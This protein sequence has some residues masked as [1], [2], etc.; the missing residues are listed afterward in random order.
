M[1][2]PLRNLSEN[3]IRAFRLIR[4]INFDPKK[5]TGPL[6]I[7]V[8]MTSAC[9]YKCYFCN[10]HSYLKEKC[11][12]VQS[13]PDETIDCLLEDIRLLNIQEILF[14]GDGE[15]F[16]HKRFL[17]IIDACKERKDKILTN[18]SK[19]RQVS[20]SVFANI[21]K[22]TISLNSIDDE[23]HRLIHGYHGNSQ[24]PYILG[25]IERLLSLPRARKKL[26]INYVVTKDNLEELETTFELSHKWNIFCS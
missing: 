25:N 13:L 10:A 12:Q 5:T 11:P 4:I 20:A 21:H 24:L 18:G 1:A 7:E 22:L 14:A 2:F 17:D 23:T 19:H 16:L 6:S 15:P 3:I 9:N 8:N 26:Q